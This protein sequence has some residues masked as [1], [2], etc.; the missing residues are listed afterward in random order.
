MG[1]R[2][3]SLL[4][5]LLL[6]APLAAKA[7][8]PEE[9]YFAARDGYIAKIKAIS[10]AKKL[11]DDTSKLHDAALDELGKMMRP[12]V[13]PVAIAGFPSDG[14]TNL[15]SL[16]DGDFGFGL[17]DGLIF[18]SADDK[19][20]I[21]VTTEPLFAHWL[22]EH[23]DWWGAKSEN[24]PQTPQ[25]AL[26]SEAFYTQALVTDSAFSKYVALP[27]VKPAGAKFAFAML[28]ARTQ[29][30]GARTPD[31]ILVAVIQGGRVFVVSA[32]A[33]VKIEPTPACRQIWL[34]A[35]KKAAA[36]QDAYIASQLNDHSLTEAVDR[37][38]EEG[39]AAF[40]RCF[41]QSAPRDPAF[42]ALANQAQSFVNRLP[43]K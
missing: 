13:G 23:K 26:Q 41:A 7:A 25:A 33:S 43:A 37:M 12:I 29:T 5:A 6:L 27:V 16:Y 17:I 9:A 32:P 10:D 24:V 19:T 11:D 42:A 18:S 8:S 35:E 22:G 4:I 34:E 20:H 14:K 40:R 38:E 31:E 28:I 3:K 30:F 15:D 36:S 2:M 39:D 1:T 21:V